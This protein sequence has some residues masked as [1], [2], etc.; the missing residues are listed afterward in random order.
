VKLF[1][2]NLL[3]TIL[4]PGS[5]AVYLPLLIACRRDITN[6]PWLLAGGML[7]LALGT[8]I[9]AWTIWDFA[10]F[11]RGTPLP[12]DAPKKLV[13]RG[14]Y[15]YTRNPMYIGVLTIILGWAVMFATAWLLAYAILV[16]AMV[17][18]FV[19]LYEEPK[20]Q[21]LFGMEYEDYRRSVG[22]WVPQFPEKG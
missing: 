5:V 16:G 8:A 12:I 15:R 20:L 2:K 6:S 3:F 18:L 22:R 17:H 13:V 7:L 14:L 10:S 11:G 19:V 4:V 1:L 21:L 9:Y